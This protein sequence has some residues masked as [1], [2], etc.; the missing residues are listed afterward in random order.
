[1][2]ARVRRLASMFMRAARYLACLLVL[3]VP[4]LRARRGGDPRILATAVVAN[5]RRIGPGA[6]KLVQLASTRRDLIPES[7]CD[8]LMQVVDD[9]EPPRGAGPSGVDLLV[10]TAL[11]PEIRL[12]H[13]PAK[14][15]SV[16]SVVFG[17]TDDQQLAAKVMRPPDVASLTADVAL[18]RAVAKLMTRLRPGV[19][20]SLLQV[21]DAMAQQADLAREART[22]DA[23]HAALA[24]HADV[25]VPRVLHEFSDEHVLWM[26]RVPPRSSNAWSR[27][28]AERAMRVVF[29]LLFVH[30][31]AHC[32]LHAGNLYVA[33]TGALVVLDAGF[34]VKLDALTQSQFAEVFIAIAEEDV[35][36]CLGVIL[37]NATA[38]EIRAADVGALRADLA[39]LLSQASGQRSQDFSLAKFAVEL[40]SLQMRQGIVP[41]P[42]FAFPLASLMTLEGR[43]KSSYP[44]LDFQSMAAKV[45]VRAVLVGGKVRKLADRPYRQKGWLDS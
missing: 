5:A 32:D 27:S 21:L 2:T 22:L 14:H 43:I 11:A 4:A 1:M 10:R 19:G 18:L 15:G 13:D 39:A 45:I 23:V 7:A 26:E 29:E 6:V 25:I 44:D 3:L 17:A 36:T 24:D 20:R 16:A 35:D 41:V 34:V 30:G 9:A 38:E 40:M 31:L 37:E 28:D 33:D 12:T 8:I 42:Q